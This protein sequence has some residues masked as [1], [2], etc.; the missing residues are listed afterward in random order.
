VTEKEMRQTAETLR[1]VRAYF[2]SER[3]K[4]MLKN[5]K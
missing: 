4:K 5:A 3:W 2:E 1:A